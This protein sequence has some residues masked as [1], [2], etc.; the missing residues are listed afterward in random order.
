MNSNFITHEPADIYHARSRSGEFMSS[1]LLADFRESPALFR[2]EIN[3]EIEQKDTPAFV[4][5]RAAHS[6]ILEGRTA[7]DRDFVVTDGPVN[8]SRT[9][10]A[11]RTLRFITALSAR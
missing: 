9:A 1:H 7:F 6:L 5:G 8:P 4:L 2:K 3:G 11:G 10:P